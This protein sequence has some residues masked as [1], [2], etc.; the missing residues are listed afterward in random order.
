MYN[1]RFP[2]TLY[3]Q[4]AKKDANGE[5]VT[6]ETGNIVYETITLDIVK[7]N[8]GEPIREGDHFVTYQA[9]SINF[10]YRT[11]TQNTKVMGDVVSAGYKVATPLFVTPLEFN[12]VLMLTDYDRTY[13][14]YV[15]KKAA[16]NWGA[17]I[18][19]NETEN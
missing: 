2:H 4:R 10:G 7:T 13:K 3:V 19:Y 1:P 8:R 12:D 14:G 15:V 6:D 9:D 11:N 16:F 5:Y 18:W 17:D